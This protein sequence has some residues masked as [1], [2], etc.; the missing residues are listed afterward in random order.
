MK[1]LAIRKFTLNTS[2]YIILGIYS[3]VVIFPLLWVFYS[4]FKTDK[5]LYQSIWGLPSKI[6]FYNFIRAW[7]V[8]G[9]QS[10]SIN[11]ILITTVSVMGVIIVGTMAGYALARYKFKGNTL[12]LFTFLSGIMIP[13]QIIITPLF[14]MF[15]NFNMLNSRSSL[16]L[17]YIAME[18]PFTIFLLTGFFKNIPNELEESA[19]LDGCNEFGVFLRIMVPIAMP[20]IIASLIFNTISIWNEYLLALVLLQNP[21]IKTLPL[22]LG[23]FAGN[24]MYNLQYVITFAGVAIITVPILIFYMFAQEK[25]THGITLTGAVKG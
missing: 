14:I 15:K 8:G 25:L 20:G 18:L 1:R 19:I 12:I 16:I 5:E 22:G 11:S 2:I 17:I 24:T 4:A 6:S 9:F 13:M 10:A 7:Q 3:V 23:Q 21:E